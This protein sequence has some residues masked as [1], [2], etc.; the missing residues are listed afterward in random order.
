MGIQER[1]C[2]VVVSGHDRDR[3]D[4]V[5]KIVKS[6]LGKYATNEISFGYSPDFVRVFFSSNMPSSESLK[7]LDLIE[8]KLESE[9]PEIQFE[10]SIE[11]P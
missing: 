7:L 10:V 2:Y 6:L 5:A 1:D 11:I 8:Q 9:F 3:G 4:K